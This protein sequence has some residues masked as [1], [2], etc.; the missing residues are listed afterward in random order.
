M[1]F[2]FVFRVKFWLVTREL[3]SAGA[4]L[5]EG[6]TLLAQHPHAALNALGRL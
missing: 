6:L 5:D 1:L 3:F 2:G 4:P